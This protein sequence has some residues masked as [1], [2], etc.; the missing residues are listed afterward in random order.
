[1]FIDTN[2]QHNRTSQLLNQLLKDVIKVIQLKI[3]VCENN[4]QS[5]LELCVIDKIEPQLYHKM[6]VLI[7]P[8]NIISFSIFK[9]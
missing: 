3:Q 8:Y 2:V 6:F 9:R 7:I 5:I 4:T 1:M